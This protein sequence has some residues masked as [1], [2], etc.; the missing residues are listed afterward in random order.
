MALAGLS[1]PGKLLFLFRIRFGL[2]AVLS[3]L[4]SVADW[5]A[6]ESAWASSTEVSRNLEVDAGMLRR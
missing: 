3:R 4:G 1:L 2:Y 5:G 6:L